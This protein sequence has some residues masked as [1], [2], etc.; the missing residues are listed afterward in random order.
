MAM[1]GQ[2]LALAI[3][4]LSL[5]FIYMILYFTFE[6]ETLTI[7]PSVLCDIVY[8]LQCCRRFKPFTFLDRSFGRCLYITGF[9]EY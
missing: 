5:M 6:F 1:Q 7:Y 9:S 8:I 3:L 4:C 2:D